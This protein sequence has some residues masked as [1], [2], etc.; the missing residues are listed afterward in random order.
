MGDISRMSIPGSLLLKIDSS[1][2]ELWKIR[3]L[4]TFQ[5]FL[6][7]MRLFGTL[8][9]EPNILELQYMKNS[10]PNYELSLP[11]VQFVRL[12]FTK[13]SEAYLIV[14]N[15]TTTEFALNFC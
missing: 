5:H 10:K 3:K 8:I 15:S 6:K 2:M 7:T 11:K 4:Q 14:G 1:Y 12:I 9:Y 13:P